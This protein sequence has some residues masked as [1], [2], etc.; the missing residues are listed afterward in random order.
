M[1]EGASPQIICDSWKEAR[2]KY[3]TCKGKYIGPKIVLT[4]VRPKKIRA[5][6][7]SRKEG[8]NKA[9]IILGVPT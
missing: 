7:A 8:I 1:K 3:S 5:L 9:E 6:S 2:L 4:S